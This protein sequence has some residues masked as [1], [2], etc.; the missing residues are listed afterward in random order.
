[1]QT[2][3]TSMN[4]SQRKLKVF[5]ALAIWVLSYGLFS[6]GNASIDSS[7]SGHF[8]MMEQSDIDRIL[9]SKPVALAEYE[10]TQSVLVG[11]RLAVNMRAKERAFEKTIIDAG[12][13]LLIASR[14]RKNS[15]PWSANK[16]HSNDEQKRLN[17][18][19]VRTK[20]IR[21]PKTPEVLWTRDYAPIM[22]VNNAGKPVLLDFNYHRDRP[23]A[24]MFAR[25]L[26]P[27]FEG[28]ER[29][30]VPLYLE[31]GNFM[32]NKRAECFL[33]E[34][35]VEANAKPASQLL[36]PV[37]RSGIV[38]PDQLTPDFAHDYVAGFVYV[39][40]FGDKRV[41]TDDIYF[42]RS[43]L[44]AT[45][46][47]Y[48][49]CEKV[50]IFKRM[51][52][53]Q[54]GHIDMY[55]KFLD[56]NTIL[57]SSLDGGR[58]AEI[59]NDEQ[60]RVAVDIKNFLD[61]R[62]REL[63]ALGYSVIT[64]PMPVPEVLRVLGVKGVVTRS[65]VNSLLIVTDK[66]KLALVPKYMTGQFP[67]AHMDGRFYQYADAKY[68]EEDLSAVEQA[69]AKAGYSVSFFNADALIRDLGAIHCA[70]MQYPK[71]TK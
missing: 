7:P 71:L 50:R 33:S 24:D 46:R 6:C 49:G 8:E 52:H 68:L 43:A 2:K 64:V 19:D 1:M 30:S 5:H 39:D 3:G 13:E 27:H 63:S 36:T 53:E 62:R 47:E 14:P 57:L 48:L 21:A 58:V 25:S 34:A 35:V 42:E 65:Y 61:E 11:H 37:Y 10:P 4:Y 41:H 28:A 16:E 44:M 32:I 54:T 17:S 67:D 9:A 59:V 12:V 18:Y 26:T 15:V 69:Y 40:E 45:L 60:Q 20:H 23:L 66:R 56:D 70:T 22:A 38:V 31:G 51:P 55:M 29:L